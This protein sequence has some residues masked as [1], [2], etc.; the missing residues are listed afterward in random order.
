[1]GLEKKLTSEWVAFDGDYEK[2]IQDIELHDG[3]IYKQCWPNAGQ[4]HCM[5]ALPGG[6]TKYVPYAEVRRVRKSLQAYY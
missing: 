6:K 2:T 5:G 4:F 1:M 3:T